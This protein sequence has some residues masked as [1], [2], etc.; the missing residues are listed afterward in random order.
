MV[1]LALVPIDEG[2]AETLR[3][4]ASVT[5]VADSNS[6]YPCRLCL[7]DAE[8]G[9]TLVLVSYDPFVLSSPYRSA[10]P[11]FLHQVQCVRWRGKG[12]PEQ[13]R[14]RQLS[15]RAF[16]VSEMM[17][18][19]IIIEGEDLEGAAV[20]LFCDDRVDFLH[21]HNASPGC[22]ALRIERSLRT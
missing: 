20:R 15:L 19:S 22:W 16:D 1:S 3:E 5:Q 7:R 21:V 14:R 10:S 11:I 12:I 13:Q 2:V 8:K 18:A 4:M 17:L 6:G 9:E